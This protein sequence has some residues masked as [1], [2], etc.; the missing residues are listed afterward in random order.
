MRI[1]C[2]GL[3]FMVTAFIISSC[4]RKENRVNV[5]RANPNIVLLLSDDHQSNLIR[6][7]GNPYIKTPYLDSLIREGTTFTQAFAETPTCVPSR[8]SLLTGCS[9][10]T[11]KSFYPLYSESGIESLQKWPRT[12]KD[13]GYTTFWTGKWNAYGDPMD[14]GVE[15]ESRIFNGGMGSHVMSFQENDITVTGFS[16]E[17][18]ADAAIDFL[19]GEH[20]KPFFMTVAFTAPHDPRTPPQEYKDMYDPMEVPFPTNFYTEYP[21]ED[22]YKSIRD[23]KLLPFPRNVDSVRNEIALYY[24]LIT[25]MDAQIGRILKSLGQ[26]GLVENTI[27]IYAS[28]NGLAIGHHGLLG[29]MSFYRHSFN[30][31]LILSGAGIPKNVKTD[32]HVYLSDI[33]PTICDIVGIDIPRTVESKSFLPILRTKKTKIHECIFGALSNLKRSVTTKK[34]K[35]IRH[36]RSEESAA[37]TDEYLFYD[38]ENDPLEIVNQI[39]NPKYSKEISYLK[40]VLKDWQIEKKDFLDPEFD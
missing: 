10:L 16:S 24:G 2:K 14:W 7:L 8:A 6:A 1:K 26:N 28:D 33:F 17:L 4:S 5:D 27:V 37:G 3:I 15:K 30:V 19:N 11:H 35:L 20:P 12:M 25:H 22:G 9:S 38:L 36:Y 34:Y 39:H 40:V 18:F 23:E 29:K 13:A 21:Y 31:P 32:A